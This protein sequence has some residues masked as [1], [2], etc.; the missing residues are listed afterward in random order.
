[1]KKKILK[2]IFFIVI[3]IIIIIFIALNRS[4]YKKEGLGIPNNIFLTWETKDNMPEAMKE[5]VN[6]IIASNTNMNVQIFDKNDRREFIE[7]HFDPDVLDAYDRLI[8]GAYKADL[9]RY[10]VLYIN[11]GIYMDIKFTPED[12]FNFN[13]I[14]DKE[15]F[16]IHPLDR[17]VYNGFIVCYP[18][19]E[20]MLNCIRKIVENVRT[21]YYGDNYLYPTGPLLLASF[22]TDEEFAKCDMR[23][24]TIY[25]EKTD[26][27][28]ISLVQE[29]GNETTIIKLNKTIHSEQ[30]SEKH[31]AELWNERNIYLTNE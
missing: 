18:E 17:Q 4:Y 26:D 11:G 3:I 30:K 2:N 9:W 10:C 25:Y 14:L 24:H 5:N 23:I 29:N 8:P 7:K 1:M 15:H 6:K 12:D 27:D 31:Y 16:V 19:N 20:K 22:F 28:Y 13:T 21:E